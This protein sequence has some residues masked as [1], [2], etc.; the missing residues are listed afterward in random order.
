MKN[1]YF[2][3]M[4][5]SS[6]K[7]AKN[8]KRQHEV[9]ADGNVLYH[10]Y[11]NPDCQKTEGWWDDVAFKLG[12]Q[13]V[14]V[15]WT[16]PR[17]RFSDVTSDLAHTATDHMYDRSDDW[18]TGGEKIY[19]KIG[20]NKNRK[21]HI[22]TRMPESSTSTKNWVA[23][24]RDS[25]REIRATTDIVIRPSMKIEQISWARGVS[26]CAPWEAIDVTSVN[27]MA[28]EVKRILGGEVTLEELFPG[29]TYTKDDWANESFNQRMS[30]HE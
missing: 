17:M 25:E 4:R 15:W 10:V 16:H 7:Y 8:W 22:M 9:N 12:S 11:D 5:A 29:Y 2:D 24:L 19:K 20:K 28:N 1:K 3:L 23:A 18:L 14:I 26:I 30:K 21:R 13:V 27:H 6:K